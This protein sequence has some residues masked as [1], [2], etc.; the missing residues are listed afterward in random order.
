[1][2]IRLNTAFS[3]SLINTTILT[4]STGIIF[5]GDCERFAHCSAKNLIE[6]GLM[7]ENF[8]SKM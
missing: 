5:G 7:G 6:L 4:I 8:H 1:M 3:L 2:L